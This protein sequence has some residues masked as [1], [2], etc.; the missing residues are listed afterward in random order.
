MQDLHDVYNLVNN[1]EKINFSKLELDPDLNLYSVGFDVL[2][3]SNAI[4][5]DTR[6]LASD[7]WE[8]TGKVQH[9]YYEWINDFY[10]VEKITNNVVFG[11]FEDIVYA[12]DKDTYDRFRA[13]IKVN[14]WDYMD[15]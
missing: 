7:T 6:A 11:N 13:E 9:D 15:I 10:A 5:L 4:T 3:S 1:Y 14:N 8:V 2:Y 12:T